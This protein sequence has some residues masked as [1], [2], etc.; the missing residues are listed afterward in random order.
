VPKGEIRSDSVEIG[1][2]PH[3]PIITADHI[4]YK[5]AIFWGAQAASL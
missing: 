4:A 3:G 2:W 1:C 5:S